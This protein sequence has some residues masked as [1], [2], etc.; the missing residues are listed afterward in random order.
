MGGDPDADAVAAQRLDLLEV[1]GDGLLAEPLDAAAEIA[2][3]EEDERDPGL[4]RR[5]GGRTGLVEAEVVEL[6]D[7]REAVGAQLPVDLDVLAADLLDGQRLGERDHPVAPRPEV[8]AAVAAAQGA[9]ERMAVRVD[10]AG[11][12]HRRILSVCGVGSRTP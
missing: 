1:L 9:L 6:A 12:L 7:R 11:N 3:V 10:E 5:L 4:G 2:G 8:A